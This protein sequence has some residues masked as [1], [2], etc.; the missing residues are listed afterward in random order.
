MWAAAGWHGAHTLSYECICAHVRMSININRMVSRSDSIA[1]PIR[2]MSIH[3]KSISC[4]VVGI[5]IQNK[6]IYILRGGDSGR[7]TRP[8]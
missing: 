3:T 7:L 6:Y 1:A 5:D 8:A 2:R 4:T